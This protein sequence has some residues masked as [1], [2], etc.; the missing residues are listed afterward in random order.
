MSS[1]IDD[2]SS[3]AEYGVTSAPFSQFI[4]KLSGRCDLACDYSYVY[5]MADQRWRAQPSLM[6]PDVVRRTAERI[7]EHAARHDL[8][9]VSVVL[10]GGEPLLA[11]PA[12]LS[13]AVEA[14]AH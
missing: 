1:N 5:T 13:A 9:R 14:H 2:R 11:G 8:D 12:G 10:H 4:L 3:Q 6:S 7:G